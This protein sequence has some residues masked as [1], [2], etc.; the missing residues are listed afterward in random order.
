MKLMLEDVKRDELIKMRTGLVLA[1]TCVHFKLLFSIAGLSG[2]WA[3]LFVSAVALS[4][5]LRTPC[6][7]IKKK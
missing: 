5:S 3:W 4:S 6:T 7:C 2:L 1:D